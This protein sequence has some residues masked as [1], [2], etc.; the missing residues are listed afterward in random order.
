MSTEPITVRGAV[1]PAVSSAGVA[2]GPQPPPPEASTKP[3]TTPSGDRNFEPCGE[4]RAVATFGGRSENF[5]RM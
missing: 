2:T 5:S 3:A 1:L 4:V